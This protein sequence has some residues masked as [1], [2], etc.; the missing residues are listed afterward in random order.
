M[1][2]LLRDSVKTLLKLK[3]YTKNDRRKLIQPLTGYYFEIENMV[4]KDKLYFFFT[5]FLY[6]EILLE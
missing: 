4:A 1:L 3:L 5:F 6:N 2:T